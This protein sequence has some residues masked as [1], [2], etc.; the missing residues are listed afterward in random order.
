MVENDESGDPQVRVTDRRSFTSTGDLRS[1][2]ESE[3]E[4]AGSGTTGEGSG[5]VPEPAFP[6][7]VNFELLVQSFYVRALIQLG[8]LEDPSTGNRSPNREE[9]RLTIDLLGVLHEKTRGNLEPDENDHL[10][11]ILYH[12]R[13]RFAQHPPA[14]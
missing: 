12:L 13:M 14:P 4:P 5:A 10:E 8:D 11:R 9:A 3:S 2:A 6:G 1:G 7:S